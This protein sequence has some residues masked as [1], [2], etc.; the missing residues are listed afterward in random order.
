MIISNFFILHVPVTILFL[1]RNAGASSFVAPFV[2]PG[3]VFVRILSP[4][5]SLLTSNHGATNQP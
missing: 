4:S 5:T 3:K 2:G 1:R